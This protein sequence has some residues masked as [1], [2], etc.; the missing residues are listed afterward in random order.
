MA[1]AMQQALA[2][3]PTHTHMVHQL[4]LQPWWRDGVEVVAKAYL[5]DQTWELLVAYAGAYYAVVYDALTD[6]CDSIEPLRDD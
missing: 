4:E 1:L 6:Q 3:F 5:G 2:L